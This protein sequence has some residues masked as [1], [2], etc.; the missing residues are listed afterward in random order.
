MDSVMKGLMGVM[1]LPQNFW[2]ATAPVCWHRY[3]AFYYVEM[4][5]WSKKQISRPSVALCDQKHKTDIRR[6][7]FVRVKYYNKQCNEVDTLT[8]LD[9]QTGRGAGLC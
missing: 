4:Q 2:A 5:W 7:N 3:T 1:P 9:L 8:D 6:G